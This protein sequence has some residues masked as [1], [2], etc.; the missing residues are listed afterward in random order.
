MVLHILKGDPMLWNDKQ[1]CRGLKQDVMENLQTELAEL[2]SEWISCSAHFIAILLP[3]VEGWWQ[4]MAV[5]DRQHPRSR[6]EHQDCPVPHMMLGESDSVP[7]LV[8]SAPASTARMGQVEE[9]GSHSLRVPI[10]QPRGRPLKQCPAKTGTQNSPPSSPDRDGVDSDGYSMVSKTPRAHHHSRSRRGEK[11]L[12][13]THLDMLIFKLTDLNADV[14]Y[15]LWRF[16]VQGW[17]DQY[18]E[19]SMISHIYNSLR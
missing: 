13:P 16:Y 1:G 10:S 18:P 17:L 2:F 5:S 14:I 6:V 9:G 12:A 7:P 4:A 8:G 11:W 3:L 19:E 15:T